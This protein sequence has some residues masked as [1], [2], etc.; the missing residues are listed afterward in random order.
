MLLRGGIAH[1]QFFADN[2]RVCTRRKHTINAWL[3]HGRS[4][5]ASGCTL[6]SPRPHTISSHVCPPTYGGVGCIV[7][8]PYPPCVHGVVVL[9]IRASTWTACSTPINAHLTIKRTQPLGRTFA[10]LWLRWTPVQRA[11]LRGTPGRRSLFSGTPLPTTQGLWI[12][13]IH[14]CARNVLFVMCLRVGCWCAS[15]QSYSFALC[16]H[17]A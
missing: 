16:T 15:L 1:W 17:D 2:H 13:S 9:Q 14:V 5:I 6:Q 3:T 8:Y 11:P 7:V 12:V 4:T 10:A